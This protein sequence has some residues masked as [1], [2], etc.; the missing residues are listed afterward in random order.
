MIT[1]TDKIIM[2]LDRFGSITALDALGDLGIM[3]LAAR[4]G[5]LRKDGVD[6]KTDME[7][8]KNRFDERIKIARYKLA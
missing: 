7:Y 3:R 2:Y 8:V 6:I 4:I 5:E 1:Q